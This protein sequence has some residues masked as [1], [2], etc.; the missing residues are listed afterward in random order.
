MRLN[1]AEYKCPTHGVDLTGEVTV[2]VEDSVFT[3]QIV[4]FVRGVVGRPAGP[5][6][7]KVAVTCPGQA[8]ASQPHSLIC[9]GTYVQ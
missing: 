4:T 2:A 3:V 1:P 8:D 9:T 7:F 5:K 6:P